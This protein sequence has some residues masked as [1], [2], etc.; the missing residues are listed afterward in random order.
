MASGVSDTRR[1]CSPGILPLVCG[2]LAVASAPAFP[3]LFTRQG[4]EVGGIGA[5]LAGVSAGLGVAGGGWPGWAL[6]LGLRSKNLLVIRLGVDHLLALLVLAE[7]YG[8]LLLLAKLLAHAVVDGPATTEQD[9]INWRETINSDR[10]IPVDPAVKVYINGETVV[11]P[12]APAVIGIG[13]R[14]D[15]EKQGR[16]FHSW[17]NQ[18]MQGIIGRA[19]QRKGVE[20]TRV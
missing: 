5:A 9:A 3:V 17:A 20:R 13:V 16:P 4:F 12:M 10:L 11:Q 19:S 6:A 7:P 8:A 2:V 1:G 14:R 18:P 15:H